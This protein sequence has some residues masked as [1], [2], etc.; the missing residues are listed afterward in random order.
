MD[1]DALAMLLL[2]AI[3]IGL[4][5]SGVVW[6]IYHIV[7]WLNPTTFTEKIIVLVVFLLF[8]VICLHL[9]R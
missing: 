9:A 4:L 3:I 2:L 8:F 5:I 7:L 1:T 6:V